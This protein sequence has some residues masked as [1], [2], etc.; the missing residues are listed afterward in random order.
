MVRHGSPVCSASALLEKLFINLFDMQRV[1]DP[2]PYIVADHQARQLIAVYQH[3]ALAQMLCSLLRRVGKSG[4]CDEE[5]L[6]GLVP[7]QTPK[8]SRIAPGPILLPFA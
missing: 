6:G 4:G 8:K 2:A 7:V 3:N 1:F 5:S